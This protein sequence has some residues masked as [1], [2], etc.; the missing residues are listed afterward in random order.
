MQ[1]TA[2]ELDIRSKRNAVAIAMYVAII[3]FSMLFLT[4][5]MGYAMYRLKAS[6]WPPMGYEK[7]SLVMPSI[8]LAVV[9]L[10]SLFMEL[11]KKYLS[12]GLLAKS[13]RNYISTTLL[14]FGFLML[15]FLFWKNLNSSGLYMNSGIFGS[16]IFAFSWI[17]VAHMIL[18]IGALIWF[19]PRIIR[20]KK[21]EHS[22]IFKIESIAS[23]W[24]FLG[25]V[26]FLIYVFIFV[27]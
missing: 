7:V 21:C 9:L 19:L 17:H 25:V 10:S 12:L 14:G 2:N 13:R 20:L 16:L 1:S 6:N 15:Q 11:S 8:S 26:W 18:G 22:D 3:S 23:F 4:L 27:I 5:F 24:H